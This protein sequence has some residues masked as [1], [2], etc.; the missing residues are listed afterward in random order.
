MLA[1]RSHARTIYELALKPILL[2]LCRRSARSFLGEQ[3]V[4][5]W[6]MGTLIIILSSH[7]PQPTWHSVSVVRGVLFFASHTP[8]DVDMGSIFMH[9]MVE[10][11]V[12]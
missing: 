2:A 12:L 10:G 9:H 8:H 3:S 7:T 11:Q 4:V 5:Y 6:G 1:S